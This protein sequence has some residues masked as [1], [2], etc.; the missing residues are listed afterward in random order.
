[1]KD[2]D[3]NGSEKHSSMYQ[4]HTTRWHLK[5]ES[6]GGDHVNSCVSEVESNSWIPHQFLKSK[7]SDFN[8]KI[9]KSQ[10]LYCHEYN[11]EYESG[12]KGTVNQ[13]V[14]LTLIII[15]TNKQKLQMES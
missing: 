1:M 3:S 2:K 8:H 6:R 7:T 12:K 11:K 9:Q 5:S 13:A 14:I 4:M 15:K 10:Q